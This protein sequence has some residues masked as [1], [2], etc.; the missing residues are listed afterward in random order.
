MREAIKCYFLVTD[1]ISHA[2]YKLL[3]INV[4]LFWIK[5]NSILSTLA[6]SSVRNV[7]TYFFIL[8]VYY[9]YTLNTSILKH[10]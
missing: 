8:Q 5:Q 3:M 2:D 1:Y 7:E 10:S 9:Q 6:K 4:R